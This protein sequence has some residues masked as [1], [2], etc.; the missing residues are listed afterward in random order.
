[1]ENERHVDPHIAGKRDNRSI[2][3]AVSALAGRQ[4][5]VV[6]R[7]QLLDAGFSKHEVDRLV[8]ARHLHTV[9]R[10]VYAVGHKALSREGR[11]KA[12]VLAAG[13]GAVLSHYAAADLH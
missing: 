7:A 6:E 9:F 1:M 8:A 12:A 3:A 10:G 11:Y 2:G 13:H 4:K 5:G